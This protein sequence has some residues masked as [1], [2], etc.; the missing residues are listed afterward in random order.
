MAAPRPT[1]QQ[2]CS[3]TGMAAPF[4]AGIAVLPAQAHPG[5]A[6]A[7]R[8]DLLPGGCRR[9]SNPLADWSV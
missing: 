6:G 9:R 3:G 2:T 5:V 7:A 1:L 8:R 4:V